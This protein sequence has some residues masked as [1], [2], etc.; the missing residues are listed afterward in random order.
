MG[1]KVIV[2]HAMLAR[3]TSLTGTTGS[4]KPL[5]YN[6]SAGSFLMGLT[7]ASKP[8]DPAMFPTLLNGSYFTNTLPLSWSAG[9]AFVTV[10]PVAYNCKQENYVE[11]PAHVS[12]LS[13]LWTRVDH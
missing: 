8:G 5:P 9:L 3:L 12:S 6:H 2:Y 1:S 11:D 7:D 4:P 13:P 10:F